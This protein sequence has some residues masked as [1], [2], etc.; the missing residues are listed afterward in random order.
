MDKKREPISKK[1]L[2]KLQK[3]FFLHSFYLE[4]N[5]IIELI[6]SLLPSRTIV[7]TNSNKIKL[8]Y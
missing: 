7:E 4:S 5:K 3:D 1:D 8:N 2:L 6:N